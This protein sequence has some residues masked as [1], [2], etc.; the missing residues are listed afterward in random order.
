MRKALRE[1][2]TLRAYNRAISAG[3]FE[4]FS[5]SVGS[6]RLEVLGYRSKVIGSRSKVLGPTT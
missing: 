6:L 2:E 5:H 4:S 1:L 3:S